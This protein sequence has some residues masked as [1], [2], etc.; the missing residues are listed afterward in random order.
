MSVDE[1]TEE[2]QVEEA[3]VV[4]AP[5]TAVEEQE[6]EVQSEPEAPIANEDLSDDDI[7]KSD[8]PQSLK[9]ALKRANRRLRRERQSR[10]KLEEK[11]NSFESRFT[12]IDSQKESESLLK[13][14]QDEL[15][16]DPDQTQKLYRNSIVTGKLYQ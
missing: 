11:V 16:L 7:D 4:D 2:Q 1:K 10:A 13:E 3:P 8:A 9:T 12:D 15:G 6:V 5:E 14:M